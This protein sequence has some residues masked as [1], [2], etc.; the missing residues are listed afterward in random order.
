MWVVALLLAMLIA[1]AAGPAARAEDP[2][3]ADVAVRVSSSLSIAVGEEGT[4][5]IRVL[6]LGPAVAT[7]VT[8]HNVITGPADVVAVVPA[9][10]GVTCTGTST[11]SCSTA[12]LSAG[13]WIY[14]DVRYT[15]TDVGTI[16]TSASASAAEADPDLTNNSDTRSTSVEPWT[17]ISASVT[18][19]R[20]VGGAVTGFIYTVTNHGPTDAP[21]AVAQISIGSYGTIRVVKGTGPCRPFSHFSPS[22]FLGP[23]WLCTLGAL[24]VNGTAVVEVTTVDVNYSLYD[25]GGASALGGTTGIYAEPRGVIERQENLANNVASWSDEG[26]GAYV[27]TCPVLDHRYLCSDHWW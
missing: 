3:E 1:G 8:L 13:S 5:R 6:N 19:V 4:L 7:S 21:G 23:G 20:D 26:T 9:Q 18:P 11:F 17:D 22:T 24:P 2:P 16:T 14:V 25:R 15:A 27:P 12:E 10:G